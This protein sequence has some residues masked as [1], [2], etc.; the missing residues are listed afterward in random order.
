[1]SGR[2]F[3]SQIN[4]PIRLWYGNEVFNSPASGSDKRFTPAGVFANQGSKEENDSI[5]SF[6][7]ECWFTE[8]SLKF[9]LTSH[10]RNQ[11]HFPED[12]QLN[13]S[14]SFE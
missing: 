1:M 7:N 14:K 4:D 12:F 5:K 6:R 11:E 8:I 2:V 10:P 3:V 13:F 9:C